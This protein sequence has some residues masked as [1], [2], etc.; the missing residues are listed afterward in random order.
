M[1]SMFGKEQR[2]RQLIA[3]LPA[4]FTR[5]QLEQRVPPGD[6]PDCA[7]MQV[8]AGSGLGSAVVLPLS[9]QPAPSSWHLAGLGWGLGRGS[10]PSKG[11]HA[12]V[13]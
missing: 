11:L 12:C 7:R 8:S 3:D 10:L 2:K 1:P 13:C 5:V 9:C 4:L 6:F